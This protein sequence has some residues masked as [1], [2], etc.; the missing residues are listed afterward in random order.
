MVHPLFTGKVSCYSKGSLCGINWDRVGWFLVPLFCVL[1]FITELI[2]IAFLTKKS[3]FQLA[4]IGWTESS[5]TV[6]FFLFCMV[7]MTSLPVTLHLPSASLKGQSVFFGSSFLSATV[8]TH[9]TAIIEKPLLYSSFLCSALSILTLITRKIIRYVARY[10]LTN[11][12]SSKQ[13]GK[14]WEE[15][16]VFSYLK[17]VSE[18]GHCPP[19]S[20][21]LKFHNRA[22]WD[23]FKNSKTNTC[24]TA[25]LSSSISA[26]LPKP[27]GNPWSSY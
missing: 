20:E 5:V 11:Q 6:L 25:F 22:S 14:Q 17:S 16:L 8:V 23:C 7:I 9:V 3:N 21:T 15:M 26:F 13:H 10:H 27:P 4:I 19:Y 1:T 24:P 18:L 2:W 12:L